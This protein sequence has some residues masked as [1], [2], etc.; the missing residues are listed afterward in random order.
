MKERLVA[1]AHGS[2]DSE[3][4]RAVR[5]LVRRVGRRLPDVDVVESYVELAEPTF[6]SVMET[7]QEPSVVVPLLLSTGYHV[8]L[9]L[10]E[11]ARLSRFPVTLGRPLG[12]HPLLGA[13]GAML[14]R[15]AGA[16][17]DDA[18]VLVAAGSTDPDATAEALDAGR[19]L[20]A[21]W[22]APVRV[23]FLSG[24]GPGVPEVFA[25]LREQGRHRI[26]TSPYLLAPGFFATRAE[27]LA[28]AQGTVAVADVLARHPLVAEL[29]VRR[30]LAARRVALGARL[31]ASVPR[32]VA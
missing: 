2:R 21:H 7:A 26:A 25:E 22:G 28:R 12:P 8:N 17:R 29:V 16:A 20:H 32:S 30:Y 4:S 14:L 5:A 3:A 11:S 24:S 1:V 13:A 31:G 6:S 23:A 18:V 9:D 27:T 10:P 15:A 19:L